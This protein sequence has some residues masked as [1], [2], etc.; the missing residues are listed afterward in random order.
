MKDNSPQT[1]H[2]VTERYILIGWTEAA[3]KKGYLQ[4]R[5]S[6]VECT[7]WLYL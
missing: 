6:L 3:E 4:L 5:G 2:A 7:R 1:K